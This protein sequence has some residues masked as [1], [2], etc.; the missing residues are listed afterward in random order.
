MNDEW[1]SVPKDRARPR[2]GRLVFVLGM[3]LL[4][5]ITLVGRAEWVQVLRLGLGAR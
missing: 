5:G 2:T 4:V 3:T 1:I